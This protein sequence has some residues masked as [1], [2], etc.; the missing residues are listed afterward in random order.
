MPILS[1]NFS[2]TILICL[3]RN[4]RDFALVKEV[5]SGAASVVYYGLCRKSCMP[6]AIKMY[7]KGKLT[8][9]N[10]RQ[11]RMHGSMRCSMLHMCT[12]STCMILNHTESSGPKHNHT[13]YPQGDAT[14]EHAP[15]SCS[16][17]YVHVLARFNS[18]PYTH[19]LGLLHC[20]WSVR[21]PFTP[22]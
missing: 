16:M 9:L 20:R 2:Y 5:G 17:F 11:V 4:I 22:P 6:V 21:L 19:A 14:V 10:R 3:C 8:A 13:L 12:C 1:M 7:T 15:L 18:F